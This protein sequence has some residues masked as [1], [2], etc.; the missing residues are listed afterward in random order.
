MR[1]GW[2]VLRL[3]ESQR[4]QLYCRGQLVAECRASDR[5]VLRRAAPAARR[6]CT[7]ARAP[8]NECSHSRAC[9]M[10]P[11]SRDLDAATQCRTKIERIREARWC[12]VRSSEGQRPGHDLFSAG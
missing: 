12:D 3:G 8:P 10:Q 9:R 5:A 1:D 2:G 7:N 4:E 6:R 11:T